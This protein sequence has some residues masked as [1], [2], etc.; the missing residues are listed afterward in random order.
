M[1]N[2]K[3]SKDFSTS[4]YGDGPLNKKAVSIE[5]KMKGN[6][7]FVT[8]DPP[9]KDLT[10]ANAKYYVALG[11]VESGT[12]ED[13]AVKNDL[14]F[15]LVFILKQMADYVQASSNGVESVI[16][17]SGYDVN[18]KPGTIGE[19]DKPQNLVVTAGKNKGAVDISCNV[20]DNIYMYEFYY[21]DAPVIPISVW[22]MKT[23][24]KS[25]MKIDG[26]ISGKQYS[27]RVAGAGTDPSRNY[28]EIAT[29]YVL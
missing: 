6:P 29:T 2:S 7:N 1:G 18:K 21:T 16:L 8:P 28:S 24:T 25:K 4:K 17:S 9:L 22:I 5:D 3:V 26:L 14:R 27:F 13:T 19:L 10:D 20:I 12:K 23:S 11:K 15:A